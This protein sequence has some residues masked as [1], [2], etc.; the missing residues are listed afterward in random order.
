M[1]DV[2]VLQDDSIVPGK[3]PRARV[4]ETHAGQD[5]CCDC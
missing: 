3:W 2:V 1:G 4:V 5:P